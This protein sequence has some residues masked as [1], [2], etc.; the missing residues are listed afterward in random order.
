MSVF[1]E[2]T[3][4]APRY[5]YADAGAGVKETAGLTTD[6]LHCQKSSDIIGYA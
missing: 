5:V 1:E 4:G 2:T 6:I 3:S